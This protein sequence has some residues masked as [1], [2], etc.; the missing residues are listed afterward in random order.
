[1]KITRIKNEIVVNTQYLSDM[2]QKI[3]TLRVLS[4]KFEENKASFSLVK[5][6]M[7]EDHVEEELIQ[8]LADIANV[9]GF[10]MLSFET[11]IIGVGEAYQTLSYKSFSIDIKS[12][13]DESNF[14][15]FIHDIERYP[16]GVEITGI[17]QTGN[18][19]YSLN[20]NFYSLVSVGN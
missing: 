19:T 20:I 17:S 3:E 10:D 9:S 16:R 7:V 8:N 13:N 12:R 6:R 15:K 5:V 18:G 1:M 4:D 2:N 11:S 14:A